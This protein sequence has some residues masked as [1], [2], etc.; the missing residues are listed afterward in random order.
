MTETQVLQASPPEPRIDDDV[1]IDHSNRRWWALGVIA[2]AQLMVVLD[3][4]IVTIA[5]PFAQV[6]LEISDANRQWAMTAYTLIFG[7][8]LLLGGRLADYL[9]R[10]RMF[11]IGLVGFAASS[12][13]AGLAWD[14]VSFFGGRALQGA[15]AAILAPA[16]L[17]LITVTFVE[18]KERAR[19]FAVYAAVS[20]GGAAIGLIAGGA[21]TEYLSWRWTLLVNAPIAVI[22]AVGAV[23]LVARDLPATRGRGYDLPGAFTATLGLISLVY[24]F[25]RA[26]EAGWSSASTITLFVL[27]ATLLSAFVFIE[28]R[29]ANPLLPL[30]IPGEINRG[31]AYLLSLIIPIPM[32]AVFMFLS[33]YM[34]NT[35]GYKPLDAGIAFLPFPAA[36]IVAAGIASSLL[37]RIGPRIPTITG[38][39]LGIVGLLYLAQLDSDSTWLVNVL[40]AEVLIA[41]GMGLIFVSM[42]SVALHRIEERDAGVASALLNT[43]QQIGGS[44][45]LALL[46][47]IVAQVLARHPGSQAPIGSAAFKEAS[48]YSYDVAFYWGAGFFV[49]ALIV[50]VFMMRLKA[51]DM[52]DETQ[53]AVHVAA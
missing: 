41:G 52:G 3:A 9:G 51:S 34:Q 16:A 1:V 53:N 48:I 30:R 10:R 22:A 50:A 45:G 4:T 13:L 8:M 11:L 29:S 19:A 7:G 20:G 36:I 6:D 26:A 15:F 43:G 47:T 18:Q 35:L 31:G 5:L 40:P 17:S 49:L 33:Y 25:T 37:P 38:T 27:S 44:V 46:S 14:S 2:L 32:F 23:V 42:Q 21:L 39:V 28:S 24:G 12:A